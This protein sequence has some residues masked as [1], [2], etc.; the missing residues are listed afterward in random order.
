[1][2]EEGTRGRKA[3]RV[4]GSGPPALPPP[5]ALGGRAGRCACWAPPQGGLCV[6]KRKGALRN[7]KWRDSD[8]VSVEMSEC[9]RLSSLST[10]R[11]RWS[12]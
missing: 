8:R 12:R 10:L 11:R 5:P 3:V 9:E 1:V 4:G 6:N 7:R 2:R